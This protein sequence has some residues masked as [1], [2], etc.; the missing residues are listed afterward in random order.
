VAVACAGAA[1]TIMLSG[2][3]SGGEMGVPLTGAL[4]GA[5]V[6]S[7]ALTTP[8][9]EEGM[10]GLGIVGLFALLLMGRFFGQLATPHAALLF[11]GTLLCWVPELPYLRRLGPWLRGLL[12]VLSVALPV[13]AAITLAQQKFVSDS[14]RTSPGSGEPSIQDYMDFG[15]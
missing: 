7:L 14:A 5:V 2:Y 12:R 15:K 6:A 1:V 9:D 4:A 8:P 3:A 10:L 13:A 11:F